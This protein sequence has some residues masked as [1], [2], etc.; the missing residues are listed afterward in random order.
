[1]HT[2]QSTSRDFGK[3]VRDS[4]MVT[5]REKSSKLGV[6]GVNMFPAWSFPSSIEFSSMFK[7]DTWSLGMTQHAAAGVNLNMLQQA[8]PVTFP[9]ACRDHMTPH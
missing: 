2:I 8:I 4:A 3:W 1:M 9:R 5:S 6:N 7:H